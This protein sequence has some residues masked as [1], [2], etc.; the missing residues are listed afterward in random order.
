MQG[1]QVSAGGP[2]RDPGSPA[3]QRVAFR[4][5]GQRDHH[6][7]PG[8]PGRPDVVRL[9]IALQSFVHLVGQPQQRELAQRGQVADPEV[10]GEGRVDLLGGVDVPVRHPAA[11]CLRRHVDELD[12]VGGPDHRVG[13]RLPLRHA[14]DLLDDVVQRLQV[15]DVHGRD[16]VDAGVEQ[17]GH[18]LP[19]LD[20]G[21]AGH[22]GVGQLVDQGHLRPPG[23]HGVQVHLVE[24][25]VPVG[26]PGPRDDL[27]VAD[28]LGGVPAAVRLD[29]GDDDI[30]AAFLAPVPFVEQGERLADTSC[31]AEVDPQLAPAAWHRGSPDVR[32][33]L[34]THDLP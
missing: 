1:E 24:V 18:V 17:L 29:V 28:L 31:G 16:H 15:L 23:Q 12:L 6:P 34:R 21:R 10:V 20:V 19:A 32:Q 5:A 26:Q 9:A 3:D 25:G 30:G 13:N 22:V 7:L 11:Q 8:F 4:A 27:E 2:G 33:T 14:G